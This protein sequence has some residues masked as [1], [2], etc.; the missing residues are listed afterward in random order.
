MITETLINLLH[1]YKQGFRNTE[2]KF[3]N[4]VLDTGN[5]NLQDKNGNTLLMLAIENPLIISELLNAKAEID[6]TN[7]NN[8]T[9]L[10]C[11]IKKIIEEQ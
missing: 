10:L 1:E 8:E 9:A 3:I 6:I 11:S 5:I 2:W 7:N 4:K